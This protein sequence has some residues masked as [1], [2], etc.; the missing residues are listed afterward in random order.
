MKKIIYVFFIII[1]VGAKSQFLYEVSLEQA[2]DIAY[3][4][5]IMKAPS[6]EAKS[7]F[8]Y[9]NISQKETVKYNN[10][11][12]YHVVS[13]S[14]GGFVI[15]SAHKTYHPVL[16]FSFE[17]NFITPVT[18]P[19]VKMWLEN[20]S[21]KIIRSLNSTG[22]HSSIINTW[23]LYENND[24]LYFLVHKEKIVLPLLTTKWN[25]NIY[26]NEFCPPD[27]A[28]PDKKTLAGCVATAIGQVMNYFRYP[29]SG[30][31]SYTSEYTVYGIHTVDY[32]NA[33]YNWNEMPTKLT[34]S[35][36][37]VAQLLYHIGVSVD[38]HYGPHGSGMWNHK[39]A[40]SMKTFFRY[41]DSTQYNFRDTTTVNWAEMLITHLDQGIPM[42][43][44][45]WTDSQYVSG[46]AFVCDGYQ[47]SSFF[48]FNWGWGGYYDGYF[49]I[50]SIFVG[51]YDFNTM[52]EAVIYG[53]PSYNY[54][55][56]CGGTDTL[57][58]LDG[59]I[60]D[61]SGPN[62]DYLDNTLCSW[63]IMPNDT[64][65]YIE[66]DFI[67]FELIPGDTLR[68]F[69]GMDGNAPPLGNFS[70]T[71][72]PNQLVSS[73]NKMFI[74]FE[75][76]NNSTSKGFLLSYKAKQVKTCSG[77]ITL[78]A[79]TGT[80]TDGS[81][82]YNY[83]NSSFCRWIIEPP[84]AEIIKIIFTEFD[85]DTT[86]YVTITDMANGN[87]IAHLTGSQLPDTFLIWSGKVRVM[88]VAGATQN[89]KGFSL[90]YY[91]SFA[92][93]VP[94][95]LENISV[96]PNPANDYFIIS[97]YNFFLSQ[98]L[99]IRLLSSTGQMI[100]SFDKEFSNEHIKINISDIPPGFY[101]VNITFINGQSINKKISVVK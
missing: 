59:T 52:Q 76:D 1:S 22:R 95:L 56:Y 28:G 88:F 85:I 100:K 68:I 92:N 17:S 7:S 16:A 38:M 69:D 61:G 46:H 5:L 14:P 57:R 41:S 63:L 98:I 31:G 27:P 73:E 29:L 82:Q 50:D 40:H 43:Y 72:I 37:P 65:E 51:G 83:Q 54:P 71:T 94:F 6:D 48:H 81:Q 97:N 91:T 86:D 25:Q 26:Y 66:L 55:Y 11:P 77:Q 47:D 96:F 35:N 21:R 2:A 36:H 53:T 79:P 12:V 74:Q 44:A 80:I 67:K 15:V 33:Q 45:G 4:C 42:Y 75:S 24:I 90:D 18:P 84:G 101:F 62:N 32:E 78:T 58:T 39:A 60:D 99:H 8:I 89:T 3:K 49:N 9:R 30:T 23:N 70:G 10:I 34:R 13:F 20:E 93:I 64:V 19:A 87:T